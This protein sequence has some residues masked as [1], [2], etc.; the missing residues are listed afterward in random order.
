M[1]WLRGFDF[2]SDNVKALALGVLY[3]V[4]HAN[5]PL[6]IGEEHRC[7]TIVIPSEITITIAPL[8]W[9][10]KSRAGLVFP[11]I[12]ICFFLNES[13]WIEWRET[14]EVIV[15]EFIAMAEW[16]RVSE[17][18]DPSRAKWSVYIDQINET[19]WNKH[20][21]RM[22][23]GEKKTTL[24]LL[25]HWILFDWNQYIIYEQ[26][27]A[28]RSSVEQIIDQ[29][30][31]ASLDLPSNSITFCKFKH[32]IDC[33]IVRLCTDYHWQYAYL[34]RSSNSID[35]RRTG[36]SLSFTFFFSL[37]LISVTAIFIKRP[38]WI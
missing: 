17:E 12:N 24:S 7:E 5:D 16:T 15:L 10:N 3:S 11:L 21:S 13:S 37:S 28:A 20:R 33:G 18:I 26:F 27:H 19:R 8:F 38:S 32:S 34:T 2:N 23:E 9:K 36:I 1:W 31:L 22:K 6:I 30:R 29:S 14:E 4:L 35:E 25:S